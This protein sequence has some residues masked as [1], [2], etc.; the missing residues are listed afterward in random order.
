MSVQPLIDALREGG[1]ARL[2][3][4]NDMRFEAPYYLREEADGIII[5]VTTPYNFFA[6]ELTHVTFCSED[7]I[8]LF[9]QGFDHRMAIGWGDSVQTK[10][11][12]DVP[13][14]VP[15]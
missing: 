3:S 15:A 13:V 8:Q 14:V 12:F 10:I 2:Y 4:D 11:L 1:T 7:S 5:G 6:G 9:A